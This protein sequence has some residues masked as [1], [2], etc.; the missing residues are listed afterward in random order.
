[1]HERHL[2]TLRDLGRS[3]IEQ[4]LDASPMPDTR[5]ARPPA[6]R[7]ALALF[8]GHGPTRLVFEQACARLGVAC[9]TLAV[10]PSASGASAAAQASALGAHALVVRH[11]LA[12]A[13]WGAARRFDGCVINAGD[14][15]NEEPLRGLAELHA[16]RRHLPSLS[17]ARVTLV[18][19]IDHHPTGRS[20]MWGLRSLGARV[21]VVAP[22]TLASDRLVEADIRVTH[23][24]DDAVR[25]SDALYVLPLPPQGEERN[26]FPSVAEYAHLFSVTPA[27]LI[28]AGVTLPV[29][30]PGP[31]GREATSGA[32]CVIDAGP[33]L[34]ADIDITAATLASL[35]ARHPDALAA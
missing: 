1:M 8:D 27:R 26:L 16:L 32:G 2:L 7:V 24:L 6:T 14:G 21:T 17:G 30:H 28:Q 11:D 33:R 34:R 23:R 12:G 9:I 29:L 15:P 5:L 22:P 35:L 3:E 10:T 4:L 20:V 25:E 18:G 31:M 13:P 19:G